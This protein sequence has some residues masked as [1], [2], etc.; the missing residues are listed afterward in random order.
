MDLFKTFIKTSYGSREGD[1]F[2]QT[3]EKSQ[4]FI[5]SAAFDAFL[6]LLLGDEVFASEFI[7]GIM[8]KALLEQ[9][10]RLDQG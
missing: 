6:Q 1:Q 3:D 7:N 10:G 8:P 5:R 4:Q 2:I 9:A